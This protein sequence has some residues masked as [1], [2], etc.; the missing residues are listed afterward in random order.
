MIQLHPRRI[1]LRNSEGERE[2]VDLGDIEGALDRSL[3]VCGVRGS[4]LAD[5]IL[6][7][8]RDYASVADGSDEKSGWDQRSLQRILARMLIDAGYAD[9]AAVFS[10]ECRLRDESVEVE[11]RDGWDQRRIEALLRREL[12]AI[13]H[14][15]PKLGELVAEKLHGLG[16]SRVA[17]SLIVELAR[18]LLSE[19]GECER[20]QESALSAPKGDWLLAPGFWQTF[21]P[22]S[23]A[24]LVEDEILDIRP[25]S[26]L[27]PVV[28]LRLFLSR[29]VA[30][31]E[32]RPLTELRLQPLLAHTAEEIAGAIENLVRHLRNRKEGGTYVHPAHLTICGLDHVL[33][34]EFPAESKKVRQMRRQEIIDAFTRVM[35]QR[36]EHPLILKFQG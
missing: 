27:L 22:A 18:H 26:E 8:L 17:D 23:T 24:A 35:R 3:A 15:T 16:L 7:A 34:S 28:R 11:P 21:L 4:W 1:L 33:S 30:G 20:R 14:L 36:L 12:K 5:H 19:W 32:E 6:V 13:E 29:L 2:S 25:L 9:V 31:I 10:D